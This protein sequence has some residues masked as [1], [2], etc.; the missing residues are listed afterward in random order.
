V[1]ASR[2]SRSGQRG[3]TTSGYIGASGVN[4]Y[5]AHRGQSAPPAIVAP[6]PSGRAGQNLSKGRLWRF[7]GT[8]P[9]L[10]LHST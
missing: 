7:R 4:G 6:Q 2:C 8:R 9:G 3:H 10:H 5:P 1:N